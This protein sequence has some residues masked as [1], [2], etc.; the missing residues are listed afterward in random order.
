MQNTDLVRIAEIWSP[1]DLPFARV[2]L[3]PIISQNVTSGIKRARLLEEK[4]SS[5]GEELKKLQMETEQLKIICDVHTFNGIHNN[6][7]NEWIIGSLLKQI[8]ADGRMPELPE[9]FLSSIQDQLKA[10]EQN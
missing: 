2:Y 1:K 9:Q 3:D 7:V 4:I 8:L 10:I 5:E 6:K